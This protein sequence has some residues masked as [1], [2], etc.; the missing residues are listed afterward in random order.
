MTK[1]KCC[2]NCRWAK[3]K[4][5][6]GGRNRYIINGECTYEIPPLPYSLSGYR[7]KVPIQKRS[8]SGRQGETCECYMEGRYRNAGVEGGDI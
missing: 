2:K 1:E 3:W 8:I 7:G 4:K 6:R 5:D